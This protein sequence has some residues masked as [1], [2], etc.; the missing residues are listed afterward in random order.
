MVGVDTYARTLADQVDQVLPTWVERE[1]GRIMRAWSGSVPAEIAAEARLA[2]Q[3][4]R[5]DIGPRLRQ[6]LATD[7]DAQ[8]TNPLTVLRSAVVYPTAVLRAAGVPE[9]QRPEFEER[10]FPDDIYGLSP[11]S[12]RDIDESLHEPGLIW[13]AWKAKQHLD[14]RRA[15]GNR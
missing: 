10:A 4:A 15:E 11:A 9:V 5:D 6:L 14:R 12:W 2:G 3:A 1:V 13:G 8:R 7:I